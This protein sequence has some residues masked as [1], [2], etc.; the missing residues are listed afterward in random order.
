M[1]QK[2]M[3]PGVFTTETDLS[4]LAQGV[5]GI[6]ALAVGR[7]PKGPA[8]VPTFVNGLDAF[9]SIFGAPDPRFQLTYAAKNYLKNST[10]FTVVRVLGHDDGTTTTNGYTLPNITAICDASSSLQSPQALAVL[11]YSGT[12]T[13]AG[14]AT[15]A[16]NFTL[17]IPS[18]LG[19]TASFLTSSANYIAK[20]LNTDPTKYSTYGHYLADN[21]SYAKPAASASWQIAAISGSTLSFARNFEGGTSAWVTS[22][23][24]GGQVYNL[25]RFNTIPH[26]RATNDDF[27]VMISNVR[28]SPSPLAT[29]YG[30]FDIV[31]RAFSDTDQRMQALETF[32][33]VSLD[34]TSKNYILRVIGD[35]VESFDTSQRKFVG[36]GDYANKSKY[37]TVELDTTQNAP[38][39]ALPFG[40]RGYMK[41]VF[42]ASLLVPAVPDMK[43]T[44]NQY[45]RAGNV[46]PNICWG[47]SFVSGG[48]ADRMHALPNSAVTASDGDFSLANLSA[49]YVQG[50]QFW[51]Y[52][53]GLA[54]SQ[55]YSAV[56]ASS[57]LH[58][59]VLPL[60]GG[61]DGWDLRTADPTYLSNVADD[62][63]IGV[64]SLKRGLDT[65]ANPDA[66]DMNLLAVPGVHNVKVTDKARTV[67]NDRGD[68]L[69]IM[70][71]TGS[72][73]NAVVG[74]LKAREID[75]NYTACYYPDVKINDKNLNRIFRVSPSTVILGAMAFNDRVGQP[76]FA[77]AGL[78]R[79]GLSQFD[80]SDVVD[81]LTFNDRNELYDN[82]VNP[83]AT[84]PN[85]GINV[86]GQKTLQIKASSLDRINVRRLLIFA[87]KTVSS[88]AK[89]LLFEPNNPATWQRFLNAVNPILDNIRQNNGL[90]R[91]KVVM[92][93]ST[94]TTDL[95]DRNIM[96][97][98][99]FLEPT[100]SAEFISLD[101]VITNA[102]VSFGE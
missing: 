15:D 46:D 65:V 92:D 34:P 58:K 55:Q 23:P 11:H 57:S 75:D 89:L 6:G 48:I 85:E 68:A 36:S 63:D 42:S 19:V 28:P 33:A 3:S 26:G 10:S 5:A 44:I 87:K 31:I 49:S 76:W 52:V 71:V 43:L 30:T 21:F 56:F 40:H 102:G 90:N 81:R 77:P 59:F 12:L 82:R 41:P 8:F 14:V 80:V 20:V 16:N 27:K 64:T 95:V 38:P 45:D 7:T 9:V 100:K 69:F 18:V 79:G 61:F 54:A 97:G 94:N 1:A 50:R 91:F 60:R 67:V 83:I 32:T 99:I 47:V 74:Q 78:N 13:I 22:Q 17:S 84:F 25:F 53:S 72:S 24:A 51:S 88:A 70:D 37:I 35:H 2:Y 101:F 4:F 98:K 39:E 96:T 66:F 73:V 86:F 62:T 93:T 29:P